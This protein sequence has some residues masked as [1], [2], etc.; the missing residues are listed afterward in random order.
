MSHHDRIELIKASV[1]LTKLAP[2]AEGAHVLDIF[3]NIY[4]Y[5]TRTLEGS[6]KDFEDYKK[7]KKNL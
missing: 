6:S 7:W 3:E 1:E 4:Q 5:L 2:I